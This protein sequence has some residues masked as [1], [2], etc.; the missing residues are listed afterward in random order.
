MLAVDKYWYHSVDRKSLYHKKNR[1]FYRFENESID[2]RETI[3]QNYAPIADPFI[4][5]NTYQLS[6]AHAVAT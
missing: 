3:S 4:A 1:A 6:V 2:V 5:Y